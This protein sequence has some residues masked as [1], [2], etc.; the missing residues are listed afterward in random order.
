MA[1]N[2]PDA[3]KQVQDTTQRLAYLTEKL[4]KL[5]EENLR[6]EELRNQQLAQ[7]EE[8]KVRL[9]KL[10]KIA[11][12]YGV[13]IEKSKENHAEQKKLQEQ[14]DHLNKQKRI[15]TQSIDTQTKKQEAMA[16]EKKKDLEQ[17]QIRKLEILKKYNERVSELRDRAI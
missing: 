11:E 2:E 7:L 4:Q 15:L 13:S 14:L 3:M 17:L 9:E 5:D 16:L 8:L 6:A 10:N 12:H 1:E